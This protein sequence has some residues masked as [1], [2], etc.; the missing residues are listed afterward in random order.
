MPHLTLTSEFTLPLDA[1]IEDIWAFIDDREAQVRLH[2][3]IERI[4][5]VEGAWGQVNSEFVTTGHAKDGSDFMVQQRLV[6]VKRPESYVTE[7]RAPDVT[8]TSTMSFGVSNGR[9]QELRQRIVLRTRNLSLGEYAAV[10]LKSR[11]L[12]S[13]AGDDFLVAYSVLQ[14]YL[15][16]ECGYGHFDADEPEVTDPTSA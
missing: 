3:Q 9:A 1:A 6:E 7:L 14:R 16:E 12:K 11:S 8:T 10:K 2:P 13:D 4:D 15:I 5:V